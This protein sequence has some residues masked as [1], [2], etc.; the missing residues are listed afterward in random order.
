M[1]K[2][3]IKSNTFLQKV[4]DPENEIMKTEQGDRI[5]IFFNSFCSS[6]RRRGMCGVFF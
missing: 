2:V 4:I 1:K 5:I 3:F 6:Q